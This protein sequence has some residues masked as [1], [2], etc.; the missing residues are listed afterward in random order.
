MNSF[1]IIVNFSIIAIAY[2]QIGQYFA[3]MR[4]PLISGFL[5]TGMIAGPHVLGLIPK[6]AAK[7]LLF[8]DRLS[9]SCAPQVPSPRQHWA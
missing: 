5:F 9:R 3:K 2:K 1:L 7:T 6:E 8:I 4:L